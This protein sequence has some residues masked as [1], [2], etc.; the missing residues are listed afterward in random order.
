MCR[1]FLTIQ[2]VSKYPNKYPRL[3]L[4]KVTIDTLPRESINHK[5][6]DV[7]DIESI[8]NG[9]L[10]NKI[11]SITNFKTIDVKT[12]HK[13]ATEFWAIT[14]FLA[15]DYIGYQCKSVLNCLNSVINKVEVLSQLM[16]KTLKQAR[17]IS[18]DRA[19]D[20]AP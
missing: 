11:S 14:S 3:F 20:A 10:K 15:I 9:L 12:N 7:L 1:I 18:A 2:E 8:N 4:P 13:E 6:M 17:L 19:V 16:S 5:K